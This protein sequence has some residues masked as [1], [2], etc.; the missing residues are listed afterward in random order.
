MK[1]FLLPDGSLINFEQIA[2]I[3]VTCG[4]VYFYQNPRDYYSFDVDAEW[5]K[6]LLT[7]PEKLNAEDC[8]A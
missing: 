5:K 1:W 3:E 4:K 2:Y 8:G 7:L 6:F